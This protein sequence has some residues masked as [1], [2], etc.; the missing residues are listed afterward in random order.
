MFGGFYGKR[1]PGVSS[2]P[3]TVLLFLLVAVFGC[4][5]IAGLWWFSQSR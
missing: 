2:L 4:L 5:F 3:L 1:D